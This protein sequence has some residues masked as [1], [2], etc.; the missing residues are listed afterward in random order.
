MSASGDSDDNGGLTEELFKQYNEKLSKST[1]QSIW[2]QLGLTLALSIVTLLAFSLLR[3][4]HRVV[5]APKAKYSSDDK[6]PPV[7][8]K[9]IFS[10]IPPLVNTKEDK[11]L[12]TI[13][14]DAVTFLRF[15]R[16]GRWMFTLI[17]IATLGIL[18]PIDIIYNVKNVDSSR[19]DFFTSITIKNVR[20]NA[21]YG[22]VAAA[23]VVTIIVYFFLWRNYS[24]MLELRWRY[25]RSNEY[26]RMLSARS[27]IATQIPKNLQSDQGLMQIFSNL[28]IP[29]PTTAIHIGRRVGDIPKLLEQHNDSVRQLEQVL[30]TYLKNPNKIPAKRPTMRLG[31]TLCCGGRKVDAI[32]YLTKKIQREAEIVESA[33]SMI[34]EKKPQNYGFASFSSVPYA[35]LVAEKLSGKRFKGALFELAP[36]PNDIIWEN[37]PKTDV[38]RRGSTFFGSLFLVIFLIL[39]IIPLVGVAFLSSLPAVTQY[40]GFID[41]WSRNSEFTFS[42]FVGVV[43]PLLSV[44]LQLILP[45]VIRWIAKGQGNTTHTKLDRYVFGRYFLIFSLLFVIFQLVSFVVEGIGDHKSFSE[46]WENF[47]NLPDRVQTAYVQQSTY[48]ITWFPLRGFSSV[49][50]LAQVVNL[51]YISF[52]TRLFGRTPREIREWTKPPTFDYSVYY[53]NN[54]FMLTV[55]FIY[56]PLAPLVSALAAVA[57]FASA[58]IYKYQLM[59]VFTTAIETGGR[60]WRMVVNRILF[61]LLLMHALMVLTI[62]L[63]LGWIKAVSLGPAVL[64]VI[65]FKIFLSRRF[66]RKYT[67]Y[68]PD[69]EE[70]ETVAIH[71]QDAR[72][73]RLEKR[74][75][76]PALY[77]PLFTPQIHKKSQHLLAQVYSGRI[78]ETKAEIDVGGQK[79]GGAMIGGLTFAALEER[80]LEYDRK[81]YLREQNE[82][83]WE[84]RSMASTAM[85]PA[86]SKN[87]SY[88]QHHQKSGSFQAQHAAYMQYG[89]QH[90]QG[91]RRPPLAPNDSAETHE[92][93]RFPSG[94]SQERLINPR[95]QSPFPSRSA[96][97][98]HNP[99]G[100]TSSVGFH[101][102]PNPSISSLS[103]HQHVPNAS[104]SSLDFSSPP[105]GY[106][107]T[108][109]S[110]SPAQSRSASP[111]GSPHLRTASTN[112]A[113]GQQQGFAPPRR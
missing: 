52:K 45:L 23:Y 113:G 13:G 19:R 3:P 111:Y 40:V 88:Q 11:L 99:Q 10:W 46:I 73:N 22:H 47:K 100:S 8:G 77:E 83:L 56:A 44:L 29:Y 110:S 7:I 101:H 62:G 20:G 94:Q 96:S 33:R 84:T 112:S 75:G 50:D 92:L 90:G 24:K 49:F 66:D 102:Q 89:P 5:Y 85:G 38:E 106:P 55:G 82:D 57:F 80:N 103:Q 105:M 95:S 70:M 71:N 16:M 65:G 86:H 98:Y 74:F 15:L 78:E 68:I 32:D 79:V 54:I 37:L 53:A 93:A 104:M 60:L 87:D 63:Q 36:Q 58:M 1:P 109:R 27:I 41:S 43:P 108:Y 14:L 17:A 28:Q 34:L 64:S 35:H 97:P 61:A 26:Q 25:F 69:K 48:W 91:P 9:G 39:Y 18:V 107:P 67:W 59:F 21:L 72:K 4:T 2:T 12:D 30:T 31:G 42:A 6:A 51:L 81:Q 76:H